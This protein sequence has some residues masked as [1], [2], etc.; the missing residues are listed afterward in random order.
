MVLQTASI[1]TCAH[2]VA[3]GLH[4]DLVFGILPRLLLSLLLGLGIGRHPRLI[5]GLLLGLGKVICEY[6]LLPLF[7]LGLPPGLLRPAAA[8]DRRQ[9]AGS[10]R[11]LGAEAVGARQAV[12]QPVEIGAE[13]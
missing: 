4:P 2:G 8:Q 5:L 6:V 1:P 3:D 12:E 9:V 7:L 11:A 10:R 13:A